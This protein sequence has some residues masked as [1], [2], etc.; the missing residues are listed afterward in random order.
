MTALDVATKIAP[1]RL[2]LIVNGRG[3]RAGQGLEDAVKLLRDR[4]CEVRVERPQDPAEISPRILTLAPDFDAVVLG[5]GDGTLSRSAQALLDVDRPLGILP[6]G[7]AN[8]LARTLGIPQEPAGA[9]AIIAGGRLRPIDLGR[10]D[11]TLFLNAAAL[12]LSTRVTR[13]LD[14]DSKRGM[15][16]YN[17]SGARF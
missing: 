11:G 3:S 5:G 15:R 8:D 17:R 14:R 1:K 13:R 2:L 9:C 10:V 12:G 16:H 4:G 7:T 6:L